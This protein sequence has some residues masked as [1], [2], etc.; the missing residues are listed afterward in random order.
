[1]AGGF[2]GDPETLKLSLGAVGACLGPIAAYG[3]LLGAHCNLRGL[4]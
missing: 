1:M 3:G 4:L 2:L